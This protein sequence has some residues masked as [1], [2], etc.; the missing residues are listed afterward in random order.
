M[1]KEYKYIH[2]SVYIY[3]QTADSIAVKLDVK[4]KGAAILISF[5]LQMALS[6]SRGCVQK[7]STEAIAIQ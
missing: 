4:L 2:T 1:Y 7:V 3:I 6:S 5:R